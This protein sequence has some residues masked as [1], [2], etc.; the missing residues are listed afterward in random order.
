MNKKS[1]QT[2][3]HVGFMKRVEKVCFV[4]NQQGPPLATCGR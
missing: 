3:T 4:T 1:L 2:I